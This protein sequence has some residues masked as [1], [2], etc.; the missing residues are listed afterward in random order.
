MKHT[1]LFSALLAIALTAAEARANPVLQGADPDVTVVG[2]QFWMYP[3]TPQAGGGS[4]FKAFV[5]TDLKTWEDRGVILD[6]KKVPWVPVPD[7]S[8]HSAWA[9]TVLASKGRFYLYYSVGPQAKGQPSRIGVAVAD[10]PEGPFTDSGK[11]LIT[12][13]KG[14]EAIDAMAFTDPK[15]GVT[16]LYAGG[17]AGATLRV[18]ELGEDLVSL[19][20]EIEV[21]TPEK[22]TEGLFMHVR[23][24]VYYLSYSHGRWS[25]SAYSVHYATA[26]SPTGPWTYRGCVLSSDAT[27]QGPGHHAFFRNPST[28]EWFIAYHRWETTQ[29]EGRLTGGRKVAIERIAYDPNGQIQAIKMTDD[30]PPQSTISK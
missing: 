30:G 5:S 26:P 7:R 3:T 20:R 9:P 21:D 10:K 11:A 15:S 8:V 13:R 14:F 4:V 29:S 24:G 2:N 12:S 27:H 1:A 17:S 25:T 23:N 28:D 6:L 19:K 16:Y 22:F 18:W